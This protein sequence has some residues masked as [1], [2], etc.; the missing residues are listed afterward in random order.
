MKVIAVIPYYN[1]YEQLQACVESLLASTPKLEGIYI[2]D[3]STQ[4]T[5][6]ESL[7]TKDDSIK[8]FRTKAAIG[9]GAANNYGAKKAIEAGADII[10]IVNQDSLVFPDSVSA[11]VEPLTTGTAVMSTPLVYE[12]DQKELVFSRAYVKM[13]LQYLPELLSDLSLGKTQSEY[14]LRDTFCGAFIAVKTDAIRELGLFH[15]LIDMYGEDVE[16]F[17]R[18]RLNNKKV[19]IVPSSKVCHMH[20]NASA[21]GEKRDKVDLLIHKNTVVSIFLNTK[22]SFLI[23]L[24][25]WIINAIR[26]YL[27]AL[28][29]GK[30]EQCIKY[31]ATDVEI[32]FSRIS[33]IWSQ[34]GKIPEL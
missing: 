17:Q 7:C 11:L 28:N 25:N 3:N 12:Y 4:E 15:P 18:Y 9:F 22:N 26:D 33:K 6:A 19:V 29:Q 20:S 34:R 10:L 13:Y 14:E 23:C 5:Q 31:L 24:K 30:W 21:V 32:L 2:I 16:I 27:K 1:E 8:Y